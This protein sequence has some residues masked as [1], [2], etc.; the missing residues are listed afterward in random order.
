MC[1]RN[2]CDLFKDSSQVSNNTDLQKMCT[3][4]HTNTE[5]SH[6]ESQRCAHVQGKHEINERHTK[7]KYAANNT[8]PS[9][10][11]ERERGNVQNRRWPNGT[12]VLG[13]MQGM[14]GC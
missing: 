8:L 3:H 2:D 9:S 11:N 10:E 13:R 4:T 5:S 12:V 14:F 6:T 7:K 1:V